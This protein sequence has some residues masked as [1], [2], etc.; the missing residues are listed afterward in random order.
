MIINR[1][2]LYVILIVLNLLLLG[3]VTLPF[4]LGK[5]SSSVEGGAVGNIAF[6]VIDLDYQTAEINLDEIEPR[7]EDYVYKFSVANYNGEKRLE[8]NAEYNVVIRTTT[9]L[10]LEYILYENGGEVDVLTNKEIVSDSDGTYYNIM[11]TEK[12]NFGFKANEMNEYE[13][14]INF[15]K[16]YISFDYQGIIES[17]EIIVVSSQIIE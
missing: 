11:K 13:L 2:Y 5:F 4:T 14:H 3:I 12:E 10:N 6:Y 1:R 8:T 17:I 15:P 9:N 7:D 16:E